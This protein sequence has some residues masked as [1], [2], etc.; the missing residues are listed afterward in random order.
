MNNW[1][2][3]VSS[4]DVEKHI[5]LTCSPFKLLFYSKQWKILDV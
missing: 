4:A 5:L 3:I 2:C 1:E